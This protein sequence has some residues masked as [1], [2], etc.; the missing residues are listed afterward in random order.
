MILP[1]LS[2]VDIVTIQSWMI[3]HICSSL[4]LDSN[5]SSRAESLL[6]CYGYAVETALAA[7]ITPCFKMD[8]GEKDV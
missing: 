4:D 2:K 8:M 1:D 3:S 7:R 5:S 6:R